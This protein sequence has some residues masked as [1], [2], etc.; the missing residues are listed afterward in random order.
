MA[1]EDIIKYQFK[2]GQSGNPKGRPPSRVPEQLVKIMGKVQAKKFYKLSAAEITEWESALLT[3]NANQLKLLAQWDEANAY[4]KGLA[5]SILTDMKNGNTKTLD[6][7]RERVVGRPTQ[8]ME[9]T[10]RDGADFMP[11]RVLTKKEAKELLDG[12]EEE[13]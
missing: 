7:L 6:K 13:Y 3:M 1:K 9:I 5:I 12:L 2:K 10:G 4:P 8:R 11:A